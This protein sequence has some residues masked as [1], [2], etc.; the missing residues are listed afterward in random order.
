M[1]I[2]AFD[3]DGTICTNTYGNYEK[4]TPY[5]ERINLINKLYNEGNFIKLLTA[6][7]SSTG[8]N[9]REFTEKQLRSWKLNYHSLDFGKID[10]DIFIDD[11]G[12][13][14]E[15][16]FNCNRVISFY[17]SYT[18][19]GGNINFCYIFT[20]NVYPNKI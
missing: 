17:F 3:I 12:Y 16:F 20:N 14:S 6:R 19:R 5:F 18:S 1:K 7:G 11:K 8:I 9:W 10:A 4:A 2:Y 13:N 15:N